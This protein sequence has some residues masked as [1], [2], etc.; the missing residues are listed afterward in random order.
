MSIDPLYLCWWHRA[1]EDAYLA[2]MS[3]DQNPALEQRSESNWP[4][5]EELRD[6]WWDGWDL[7]ALA[8]KF[9]APGPSCRIH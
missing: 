1:G 5:S 4:R 6:A 8:P 3:R 7:A 2:G 9:T